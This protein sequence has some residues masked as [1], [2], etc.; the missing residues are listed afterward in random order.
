MNDVQR[1]VTGYVLCVSDKGDELSV[2]RW[3]VYRLVEPESNDPASMLRVVDEEGED[4]LYPR[5][6]FVT[7]DLPQ[8]AID[9]L[10]AA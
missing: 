6:W 2:Q 3:K 10:E 7:V 9:A 1:K 8:A 4:Y 5:D